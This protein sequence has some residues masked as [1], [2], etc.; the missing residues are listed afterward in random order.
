MFYNGAMRKF[1]LFIIS[2]IFSCLLF[3]QV[4]A[5]NCTEAPIKIEH[6]SFYSEALYKD[7]LF[8]VYIP[9]CL[10]ERIIGGYPVVYLLHG[11]SMGIE[12]WEEMEMDTIIREVLDQ[13][14]IPLFLTVV[15]QEDDYLR[16]MALSGFEDALIDE[17]MPW[18]DNHYNTCQER[19]CR[20]IGG[21]SRGALWAEKIGFDHPDLF[22]AVGLLSIPGTFTD[23]QSLY[24]I[25][26]KQEEDQKLRIRMDTGMNDRYR[27][28]GSEAAT[29][30]T[31]IGYSY[32]YN[33][34]PGDHDS[35][36][37][38]SQLDNYFVWFSK[39]W[40]DAQF[41]LANTQT[42]E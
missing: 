35:D 16:S 12:I 20:S 21:L 26:E 24:F 36:Y 5:Q 10:D 14:E 33:V 39:S 29:Q 37:W 6:H 4:S 23:D 41:S 13:S 40:P 34:E 9:P 25:A 30:L 42:A 17:L 22:S 19:S 38:K 2:G 15:P 1:F 18:I 31:F 28:D 7:L 11:Q 8:D 27:H 3:T 32:E